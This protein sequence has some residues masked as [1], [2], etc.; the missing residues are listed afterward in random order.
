MLLE[1]SSLVV[2]HGAKSLLFLS[3][4]VMMDESLAVQVDASELKLA[5]GSH[6]TVSPS[7]LLRVPT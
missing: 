1:C 5:V 6:G 4:S 7:L 3:N 2:F